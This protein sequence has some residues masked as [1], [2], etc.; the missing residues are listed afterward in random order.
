MTTDITPALQSGGGTLCDIWTIPSYDKTEVNGSLAQTTD[1]IRIWDFRRAIYVRDVLKTIYG[2][3]TAITQVGSG[4]SILWSL[5]NDYGGR[6]STD[7]LRLRDTQHDTLWYKSRSYLIVS[8][9]FIGIVYEDATYGTPLVLS[10][11]VRD[12]KTSGDYSVDWYGISTATV[13]VWSQL[14]VPQHIVN[15]FRSENIELLKQPSTIIGRTGYTTRYMVIANCTDTTQTIKKSVGTSNIYTMVGSFD[16][17][18]TL[19]IKDTVKSYRNLMYLYG[20]ATSDGRHYNAFLELPSTSDDAGVTP[21]WRGVLPVKYCSYAYNADTVDNTPASYGDG[22][23]D[24]YEAGVASGGGGDDRYQEGYDDGYTDGENAGYNTGYNE[25]YGVGHQVGYTDGYTDGY[26]AGVESGGGGDEENNEPQPSPD[27]K[28]YMSITIGPI[29]RDIEL[30]IMTTGSGI[31]TVDWGDEQNTVHQASG[32]NA[33]VT[34]THSYLSGGDY[35]LSIDVSDG[36]AVALGHGGN[37]TGIISQ[38]STYTGTKIRTVVIGNNISKLS[39]YVFLS[40]RS[41]TSIYI[42]DGVDFG[43]YVFQNCNNLQYVRLPSDMTI[44]PTGAFRACYALESINLPNTLTTIESYA[45]Y[46]CFGLKSIVIPDSVSDLGSYALSYCYTLDSCTL[47]VSITKLTSSMFRD[48]RTMR[49]INIPDGVTSIAGY[50]FYNNYALDTLTL[51]ASVT[52]ISD[53]AFYNAYGLLY[54]RLLPTTPPTAS[55]YTFSSFPSGCKIIVPDGCGDAYKTAT[56]WSSY[57]AR[58]YEESE[59]M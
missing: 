32:T 51:P 8:N 56:R 47:P 48:C 30:L 9:V 35:N 27:G 2:M 44:L 5:D 58:I 28:T 29:D 7:Y 17:F 4:D 10:A 55:Q 53:Y 16:A 40:I 39:S 36:V 13:P 14:D 26:T 21:T 45:F 12:I 1:N 19:L 15:D 31:V 18:G 6:D 41:L 52:S 43:D 49:S 24:G 54:I 23:T 38:S 57:A 59:V 50:M 3:E 33:K 42:P 37:T 34:L 22:Y 20:Y 25:G 11:F 46:E